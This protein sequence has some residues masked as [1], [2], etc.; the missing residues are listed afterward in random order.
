[1][2]L[3]FWNFLVENFLQAYFVC[4]LCEAERINDILQNPK[5]P[6]PNLAP[7]PDVKLQ[8]NFNL[9]FSFK[10]KSIITSSRKSKLEM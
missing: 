4:Q 9:F 6:E 10:I 1:M 2:L 8:V 3:D 5:I 7:A